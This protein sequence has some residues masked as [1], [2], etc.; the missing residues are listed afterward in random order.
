METTEPVRSLFRVVPYPI[1]ITWESSPLSSCKVT[2]RETR[3]PM[4]IVWEAYPMCDMTRVSFPGGRERLKS[5]MLLVEVASELPLTETVAPD[6]G[7]WEAERILPEIR[8]DRG[9]PWAD[10]CRDASAMAMNINR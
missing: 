1:T 8:L 9:S 10:T 5:P 6:R 3:A 2:D 4:A 7:I